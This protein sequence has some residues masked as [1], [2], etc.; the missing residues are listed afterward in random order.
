MRI[1]ITCDGISATDATRCTHCGGTL[2]DRESVHVPIRR[3][4]AESAHPL[5]GSTV[6]GKYE[7]RGVLGRGGMGIV[8]RAVHT[9]SFVEVAL[10]LLHRRLAQRQEYRDWFLAEAR[11]AGRVSHEHCARIQ[12]VGTADDGS[13]YIAMELAQGPP[14]S[15][16]LGERRPIDA[17]TVVEV[18]IQMT[19]AIVAAHEVGVVHR[20]L[21]PRNVVI[22]VRD[23]VPFVKILDFGI[24]RGLADRLP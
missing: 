19:R 6:G 24:A 14:L 4:E 22:A 20:D 1:C 13:V 8:F 3:G 10:K 17:R 18:L 2:L 11:K 16:W 21:S 23:G 12:D 7:V 9:V 5:I 15:A